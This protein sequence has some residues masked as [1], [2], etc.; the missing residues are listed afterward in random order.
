MFV[1]FVTKKNHKRAPIK[2][3]KAIHVAQRL[4]TLQTSSPDEL[5]CL[6]FLEGDDSLEAILHNRFGQYRVRGEWFRRNDE[7]LQYIKDHC[8]QDLDGLRAKKNKPWRTNQYYLRRIAGAPSSRAE[9][10]ADLLCK[11]NE[12]LK[13]RTKHQIVDIIAC[14]KEVE[15]LIDQ[16]CMDYCL[17]EDLKKIRS[18]LRD[19]LKNYSFGNWQERE[20]VLRA[21]YWPEHAQRQYI[22][23]LAAS[24]F[25]NHYGELSL[26][27]I[28]RDLFEE[29]RKSE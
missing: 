27:A 6:G 29:N 7:I 26:Q 15:K 12:E 25:P 11:V 13:V 8:V 4:S 28:A 5:V 3:G 2:I 21:E 23:S 18:K 9:I 20:R 14:A 24:W 17:K 1:Y 19:C 16:Y 10:A 22:C